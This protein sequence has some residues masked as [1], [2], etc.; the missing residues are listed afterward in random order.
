MVFI[1]I[2]LILNIIWGAFYFFYY[3]PF[4]KAIETSNGQPYIEDGY[5]YSVDPPYYLQ[6]TFNVAITKTRVMNKEGQ[7][8]SGDTADILVWPKFFEEDEYGVSVMYLVNQD[9]NER[10]YA[11]SNIYIDSSGNPQDQLSEEDSKLFQNHEDEIQ[12]LLEKVHEKWG[13]R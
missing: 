8:I 2:F 6:Y 11:S 9:K 1:A 5:A 12:L 13:I 10:N 3:K 7:D 4:E